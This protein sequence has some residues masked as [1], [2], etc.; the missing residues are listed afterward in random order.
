MKSKMKATDSFFRPPRNRDQSMGIWINEPMLRD[1]ESI[2]RAVDALADV[3]F[4]IVRLFLRN[5]NFTHRSPEIVGLVARAVERAHAR[6]VRAVLDCEP[7]LIVGGD[8]GRHYPDA[9]GCKLVRAV[10]TVS[11]GHW[12]LRFDT[13]HA[14]GTV[15]HYDGIEAA[16]LHADGVVRQVH[17]EATVRQEPR[18]Y[19]NGGIHREEN[20]TEGVAVTHRKVIELRGELRGIADGRLAAY[21]RF[22][23]HTLADFWAEGFKLYFD[24]LLACYRHVPLDGV[25]WDEP[26]IDGNWNSYRYG[27][28]FAAAFER[29]NGYQLSDKLNLL[30]EAGMSGQAVKVRLD[31]YRTLNEGLAQAQANLNAKAQELFG[32]NLIFGTHHTWQGEGG[33]NDYRAGAVDYF[34]L[35]DSMDAGYTDCSWWDQASVAY[36]YI[37]ASS[38]GRLTPSGEAEV[39]T[40]HFKPTVA[41]VRSNVNRM[42]LMDINW[43]NIWFGSDSDTCM[44]DGHYTWPHSV[45]AMQAHRQLQRALGRKRPGVDVAVWH[46]WEGVCGWNCPGLANAQKAFF[47]NTSK[48]FVERSIAAD[49]VDSRLLAESRI[50]AGRLVNPLGSYRVL[51]VPYALAMP[52]PAFDVCAAFARSGGRLIF[53]GTPV[54]FDENGKSLSANFAE[55]LGIPEMAAE[56]YM[57]GFD[58]ECTL[59]AFRPERLEACRQLASDLPNKLVSCEGEIHGVRATRNEVVF[60]TD[61]DPQQRLVEQ[62]GDA[63][64]KTVKVHAD[65]LLWRL[66]RDESGDGL[67]VVAAEDRPARGIIFWGSA[68]IEIDGGSAGL[69][70]LDRSGQLSMEGDLSW[71]TLGLGEGN[72]SNPS[73]PTKAGI[74]P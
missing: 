53:V 32:K 26:A 31:Y 9:M 27:R 74:R 73:R 18:H 20:Y 63:L 46:G 45:K 29:I 17:L 50:E 2:E 71:R 16:Y 22:S 65:N 67:V 11:D 37:L 55:L 33:I 34:R 21:A 62:F 6:G 5:S 56:H 39:N 52:R 43:F 64:A 49:F 48:L 13:P 35:N 1:P 28:A 69:F 59:P 19:Q 54:A 38:L 4:G 57:Q 12:L 44:Q 66:Y 41:N 61:L 60:L 8:M 72:D 40:W 25:G 36:A 42:S 58:V 30:D 70:T 68:V 24:D 10:S 51:V 14:V 15:P 23:S 47:L 3:G 7:H